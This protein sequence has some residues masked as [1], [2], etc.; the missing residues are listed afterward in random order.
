MNIRRKETIFLNKIY[1]LNYESIQITK[2]F[3]INIVLD[4]YSENIFYIDIWFSYQI[5]VED[6]MCI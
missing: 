5:G 6:Q 4:L 1:N 3:Q 2:T